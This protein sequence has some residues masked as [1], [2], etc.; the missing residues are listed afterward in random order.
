[1]IISV[2]SALANNLISWEVESQLHTTILTIVISDIHFLCFLLLFYIHNLKY[3][4]WTIPTKSVH[5]RVNG[6]KWGNMQY[7]KYR[8]SFAKFNP[9]NAEVQGQVFWKPFKPCHVGIHWR[10]LA[11][12]SQ[13]STHLPGFQSFFRLF[14]SFC[15]AK[16]SHIQHKS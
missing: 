16:M 13:M 8:G 2:I 15:D 4:T 1:M 10:A 11:E 6:L 9:S 12:Y 7:R 5:F 3:C 14:A